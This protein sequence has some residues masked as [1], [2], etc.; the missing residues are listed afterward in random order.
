MRL[1]GILP[2]EK[3]AQQFSLFLRKKNVSHSIDIQM[4]SLHQGYTYGI[5]IHD[6]DHLEEAKKDFEE[7]CHNPTAQ[8]FFVEPKV[9]QS[10]T[11]APSPQKEIDAT[12]EIRKYP[13]TLFSII[14]CVMIYFMNWFQESEIKKQ[15][16]AQFLPV[17]TP[18][19]FAMLYDAP[20][21]LVKYNEI[22]KTYTFDPTK[23]F[24][25]QSPEVQQAFAKL[26]ELP[27]WHG[28]YNK[29]IDKWHYP[30]GS[31]TP[32]YP[33]FENISKGQ[34]W[35][36]IS[37]CFLHIYF[38]HLL[39][40]MLWLWVLGKQIEER[41]K[42]WNMALLVLIIGIITNTVQYLVSGPLFMG[43][44]GVVLGFVGF[45]WVRQRIAPWEGYP[46]ARI[47]VIFLSFYVL[48]MLFLSFFSFLFEVFRV[49]LF[50]INIANAAHITGAL[51]GIFLGK[52]PILI[53]RRN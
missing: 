46:L 22:L 8:Q 4:D 19:Q 3:K 53:G 52:F 34:V 45:I 21:A 13:F 43:Y 2:N 7:F 12:K 49:P 39:F 26:D 37:P 20:L 50:S 18:I 14:F 36:L 1:I 51:V 16:D 47:T 24:S 33:L 23:K 9:P 5:W 6:E 15:H 35:R 30:A 25:E 40:N 27:M 29:I 42:K 41:V 10:S 48:A 44:S 11:P 31:L 28:Y 38:L 32:T 17:I